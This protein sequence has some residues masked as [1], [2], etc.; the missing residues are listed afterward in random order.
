VTD[1]EANTDLPLLGTNSLNA[2]LKSSSGA[3]LTTGSYSASN[4]FAAKMRRMMK[5][6]DVWDLRSL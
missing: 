1:S 5:Q 2:T 3:V 6:A 4:E